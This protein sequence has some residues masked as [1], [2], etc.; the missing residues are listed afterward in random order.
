[1]CV[2][3]LALKWYVLYVCRKSDMRKLTFEEINERQQSAAELKKQS[4]N[5][6]LVVCESIRSL[7]NV[8]SIF[9]TSD[10]LRVEK[11][12][13]CGFTGYPPRKEID[14]V[15]LGAADSVPWEYNENV[16]EVIKKLRMNGVQVVALE[17]TEGSSNFQ[18][19]KY[20]FPTAV[21]LGHEYDGLS[22]DA[23]DV[24]H[25]AVEIPMYGI[26]QSLNVATA[27]GIIGYELLRQYRR[28]MSD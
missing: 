21:V 25:S 20:S 5:P 23:L 27:F 22:Q 4:R 1:M 3:G 16:T 2:T 10:G 7:Y 9:R 14:K 19:F 6:I 13:L 18:E 8:G 15:A 26:K 11:I 17:H 12:Y 24:C 28:R